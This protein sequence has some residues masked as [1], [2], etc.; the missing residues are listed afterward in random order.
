MDYNWIINKWHL[1]NSQIQAIFLR[2]CLKSR[3]LY[4]KICHNFYNT[5]KNKGQKILVGGVVYK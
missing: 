1:L 5:L 2:N 4:V 3:E